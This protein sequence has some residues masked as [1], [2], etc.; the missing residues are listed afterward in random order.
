MLSSMA[1][2]TLPLLLFLRACEARI[3]AYV[4]RSNTSKIFAPLPQDRLAAHLE[5][6]HA[7]GPP[8][9]WA[10]INE[11]FRAVL[12][13]PQ[14]V[15]G[16]T[17]EAPLEVDAAVRLLA[18]RERGGWKTV[19]EIGMNAGSSAVIWLHGTD[20]QLQEFDMFERTYSRGTQSFLEAAFPSRVTFYPG[21]SQKT[22]LQYVQAVQSG[23]ASPCDLWYVDGN[24]DIPFVWQDFRLVLAS[25]AFDGWLM[26]DDYSKRYP[27]VRMAWQEYTQRGLVIPTETFMYTSSQPGVGHKGWAIGRWNT[28]AL[29]AMNRTLPAHCERKALWCDYATSPPGDAS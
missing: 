18:Q 20:A 26:A 28:T 2:N 14:N 19:C 5:N 3:R 17:A 21:P 22:V 27:G 11:T 12:N 6:V 4:P 15:G 10:W 23:E 8:D 13:Y 9:L 29:R 7:D 25:A 1:T 24:H 16:T